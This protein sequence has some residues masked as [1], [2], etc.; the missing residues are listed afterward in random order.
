MSYAVARPLH[1]VDA[2]PDERI[3]FIRKTY[4]HLG[5]AI[6]LF[7]ALEWALMHMPFAESLTMKMTA[8]R[9]H[10]AGVLVL[11]SAVGWIAD[12]WARNARS[13]PMQYMG[14]ALY[15]AA[16]VFIFLPLLYIAAHFVGADIIPKAGI[17]TAIIFGGL[18]AVVFISKRDFSWMQRGLMIASLAALALIAASLLFGFNLGTL[19]CVAMVAL[20]SGYILYETSNVLHHYPIGSHVSAALALFAALALLFWYIVQLLMKLR[21]ASDD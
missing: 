9:F 19:F 6:L 14:L 1:A 11:Y 13:L 21:A 17:I 3:E 2:A 5:G 15:V 16:E 8:T 7:I 20:A 10:W 4:A 18:S 12:R